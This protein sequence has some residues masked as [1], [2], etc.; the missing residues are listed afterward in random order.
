MNR[1]STKK[2]HSGFIYICLISRLQHVVITSLRVALFVL[3][4]NSCWVRHTL[5]YC[6]CTLHLEL[7]F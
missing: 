7:C 5:K 2:L 3:L 1:Q 4:T 6:C